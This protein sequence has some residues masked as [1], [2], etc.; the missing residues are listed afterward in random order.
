MH[1]KRFSHIAQKLGRYHESPENIFLPLGYGA[2][3]RQLT[4]SFK[5]NMNRSDDIHGV[6]KLTLPNPSP[7]KKNNSSLFLHLPL[8][9]LG[10]TE[11][12]FTDRNLGI[13]DDR[14]KPIMLSIMN[15]Q[16]AVNTYY[17]NELIAPASTRISIELLKKFDTLKINFTVL[18]KEISILENNERF[19]CEMIRLIN[20]QKHFFDSLTQE[21]LPQVQAQVKAFVSAGLSNGKSPLFQL[22]QKKYQQL[23]PFLE[24]ACGVLTS[25]KKYAAVSISLNQIIHNDRLVFNKKTM[26]ET[27]AHIVKMSWIAMIMA[28]ELDDFRE[29]EYRELGIICLGHDTGKAFIPQEILY[30]SGRLTQL[31]NEIMKSHV[32]FSFLLASKDQS[33]PDFNSFVMGL[34]HVK[35]ADHLAQSYGIFHDTPTSFYRYLNPDARNRLDQAYGLTK[36]FY[37][38]VNIAD[39]FEAITASRVYKKPSSIGKALDI[40]VKENA[41]DRVL[42]APYLN[43]LIEVMIKTLLPE[44]QVFRITDKILDLFFPAGDTT[45]GQRAYMKKYHRGIIVKSC[46]GLD[47]HLECLIFNMALKKDRKPVQLSPRLFL[48]NL[49]F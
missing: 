21:N 1:E 18:K 13:F 24:A 10:K 37:R 39:T 42:Y 5:K 14:F 43:T 4:R 29:D 46:K 3:H 41:K 40:M 49:F 34:H 48:E 27:I 6:Q 17:G 33:F 15:R 7:L 47:Q 36:K 45:S 20:T 16:L 31:E 9:K 35:E 28:H 22:L 26:G 12:I 23:H 8:K 30:K 11:S 44:N 38:I 32:L 19:D 25:D 2:D